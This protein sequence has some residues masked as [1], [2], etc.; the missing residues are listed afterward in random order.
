[1]VRRSVSE[2][3]TF[4]FVAD[5]GKNSVSVGL[6]GNDSQATFELLGDLSSQV[7]VEVPERRVVPGAGIEPAL[8]LRKN[9]F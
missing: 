8:S 7:L 2:G 1:L 9:G 4:P 5:S 3:G 6:I